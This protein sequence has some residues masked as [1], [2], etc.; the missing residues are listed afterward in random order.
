MNRQPFF[1][2]SILFLSAALVVAGAVLT[3]PHTSTAGDRQQIEGEA[4]NNLTPNHQLEV[5]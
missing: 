2:I 3:Y 5:N 4:L 1:Q